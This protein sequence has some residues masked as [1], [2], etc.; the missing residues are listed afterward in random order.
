MTQ[1]QKQILR[2]VLYPLFYVALLGLFFYWT[3]PFERLKDRLLVEFN[4]RQPAGPGVRM[5]IDALDGY[6][7]SGIEAEGVRLIS[8][9]PAVSAD[10]ESEGEDKPK[11]KP[12]PKVVT[13]DEVH[14]RVSLLR[15]L[16]GTTHVTFGADAFG[17]EISGSTS[18]AGGARRIVIQLDNVGLN[19]LPLISDLVGLPMTGAMTGSIELLLPEQK[20]SQA[21]GKISL[22]ATDVTVGDGKAKIRDAIALPKLDAG[23][24]E[25]E[26][27]VNEG[28]ADIQKLGAKGADLELVSDGK[29][30]LRD[31]FD[32]S[33][34]ELGL[35]FKFS[36]AYKNKSDIT[37]G[38]FG[39]P[40]SNVPGLFDM[41]PKNQRAKRPDGFY[42]FR[43]SGQMSKLDTQPAPLG[44]SGV[45]SP[46]R[47]PMRGFTP[48]G[49]EP[50]E[51]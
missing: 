27:D 46:A 49:R 9:P 44:A 6:W 35:R 7:F 2:A 1:R 4:A 17:G 47:G 19:D 50:G 38:L 20:L 28:R 21:E 37:R 16:F 25:L 22:R 10:D 45:M 34:L 11:K 29:I 36:D 42:A 41:D 31:P 23:E 12:E 3:F 39:E 24:L 43:V 13:I 8:P 51:P 5:E 14:V 48:P 26:A 33:L 30:R 15:L 18:D 32:S 40:G